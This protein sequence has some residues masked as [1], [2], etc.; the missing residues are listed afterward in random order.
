MA[1]IDY[2]CDEC[3]K[4]IRA[5]VGQAAA[6][7]RLRWC[8]SYR[9]PFC[10][11]AMEMDGIDLPPEEYRNKIIAEEGEWRISIPETGLQSKAKILKALRKVLNLSIEEASTIIK[12][13]PYTSS[14]T[15][16]EIFWLQKFLLSENIQSLV[17]K[18]HNN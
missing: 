3:Q 18:K 8:L 15:K 5:Y 14:G 7:D 11:S 13:F 12:T 9:C 16:A 10:N 1:Q 17:E 6:G 4:V 2:R